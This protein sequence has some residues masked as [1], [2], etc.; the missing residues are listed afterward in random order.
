M[1]RRYGNYLKT[2]LNYLC[3]KGVFK[4]MLILSTLLCSCC[5]CWNLHKQMWLIFISFGFPL[6]QYLKIYFHKIKRNIYWKCAWREGHS[7]YQYLIQSIIDNSQHDI[8]F[9]AFFL[10]PHIRNLFLLVY[11]SH[12]ELIIN[13]WYKKKARLT[14][15]KDASRLSLAVCL[16][17]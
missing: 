8:Y 1:T 5:G 4:I 11:W 6:S 13:I 9:I 7:D 14:R 3:L 12:S 15:T 16:T 17:K 10:D 2:G